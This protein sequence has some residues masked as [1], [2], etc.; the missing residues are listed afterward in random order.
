MQIYS[1]RKLIRQ[2]KYALLKLTSFP[3]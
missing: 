3:E 1:I 2:F